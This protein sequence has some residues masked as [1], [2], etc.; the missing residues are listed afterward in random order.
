MIRIN[1]LPHREIKRK[2]QQKEFLT[3]L[4]AVAGLGIAIWF[5]V[6]T[7]LGERLQE[8]SGRND[9]L[10]KEIADLDKQIDEI[11]KLKEQTAA[12]L[13][14]KKIVES[15]QS[16]RNE[17]VSLLDQLV[18]QMPDGIYLKGVQQKGEKVTINGYAQSN[19]RV[20]T[21]MRNLDASPYLERPNLVE[22]KAVS[23]K[24]SR[25]NEFTLTISLTRVQVEEEKGGKKKPAAPNRTSAVGWVVQPIASNEASTAH[26][27]SR[28]T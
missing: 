1:L 12:L 3:M 26:P 14:R 20:S 27:D 2:R 22:I 11:K 18:R 8:Q 6:H 21:F 5:A 23:D 24:N 4:G 28:A 17:T 19:A 25:I 10:G 13:Q 15:L 16:N 7:Y 9:Y